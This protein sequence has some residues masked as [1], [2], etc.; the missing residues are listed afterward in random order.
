MGFMLQR[1]RGMISPDTRLVDSRNVIG[2]TPLLRALADGRIP[3][4]KVGTI[5][6]RQ[7]IMN[8]IIENTCP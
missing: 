1:T 5:I 2:E 3:V 4:I 8:S 7:L 6:R